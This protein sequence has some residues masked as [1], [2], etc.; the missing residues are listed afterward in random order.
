[1]Y[2]AVQRGEDV[3]LRCFIIYLH[4]GILFFILAWVTL[5]LAAL[6][7]CFKSMMK[8]TTS[9]TKRFTFSWNNAKCLVTETTMS[10]ITQRNRR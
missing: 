9:K 2:S 7:F 1:M 6:V 10:I 4:Y 5:W 8:R 3:W